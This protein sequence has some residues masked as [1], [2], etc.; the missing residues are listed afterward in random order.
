ME[1]KLLC[2]TAG[3]TKEKGMDAL[4]TG[5]AKSTFTENYFKN[6]VGK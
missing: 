5:C 1:P 2:S 6:L 3:S 4:A